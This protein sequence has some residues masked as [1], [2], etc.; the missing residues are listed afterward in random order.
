VFITTR[1]RR[2]ILHTVDIKASI[3]N[4]MTAADYTVTHS[5]LLC[6]E[7]SEYYFT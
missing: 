2:T 1:A 7:W 4:S 6:L 3:S 5:C